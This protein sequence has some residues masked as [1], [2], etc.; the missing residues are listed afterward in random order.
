MWEICFELL[1]V[2]EQL[3]IFNCTVLYHT[4][5]SLASIFL[6][7]VQNLCNTIETIFHFYG[8]HKSAVAFKKQRGTST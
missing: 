4:A 8:A 5:L 7:S 3:T 6:A 2:K 1:S